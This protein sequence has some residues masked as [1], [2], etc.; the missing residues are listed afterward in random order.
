MRLF[1]SALV[2]LAVVAV[3]APLT[4]HA[5]SA[6]T[7][8]SAIAKDLIAKERAA[9]DA[10]AKMDLKRYYQAIGWEGV[11]ADPMGT[12]RTTEQSN[13]MAQ[14]RIDNYNLDD[15]QVVWLGESSAVVT[16][17]W[18]GKATR[19]GQPLPPN[20]IASTVWTRRGDNWVVASHQET[21][22]IAAKK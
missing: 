20:M 3:V 9:I 18:T 13:M 16:Y 14:T 21:P 6:P 4:A 12:L 8:Q 5:Q 17:R 1:V 19:F 15:F 11:L 7:T 2:G 22:T 10:F